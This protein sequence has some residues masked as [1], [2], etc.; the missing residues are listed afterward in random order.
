MTRILIGSAGRRVYLVEW[1]RQA[2]R[3]CEVI[4][5][6][7]ITDHDPMAATTAF[8]DASHVV[9]RYADPDYPR[10]MADLVD[11]I[12]PDLYFSLNDHELFAMAG[13]LADR[14]RRTGCRVLSL[15]VESQ[16]VVTDKY[17]MASALAG[18]GVLT[19][20]TVLA[21]DSEGLRRMA[22]LSRSLIVK[23][24]FGSG[25]VGLHR[26]DAAQADLVVSGLA[27]H[28]SPVA[29]E[30][31]VQPEITGC[32][33]GLDIV[34]GLR[35]GRRPAA[36]L[37]REKVAMRSGEANV[38]TTVDPAPFHALAEALTGL[39]E[40]QGLIDIDV[41]D[42]GG[43]FFVLDINPRFGGGYPFNHQAGADVPAFYVADLHGMAPP[44]GWAEYEIGRTV[45]KYDSLAVL[46]DRG[47][48]SPGARSSYEPQAPN[49]CTAVDQSST[50]GV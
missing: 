31:I 49:P 33:Y 6:V 27:R 18:C 12:A 47:T 19:P 38:A 46:A 23:R 13:P 20:P 45:A 21:G 14:L 16:R 17:A 8:A 44:P 39:L 26:V 24:R 9:P 10:A 43:Q 28:G 1:F 25:S 34:T 7:H 37:A 22:A 32:H 35:G 15:S 42:A 36:V 41:V 30:W 2:L 50:V 11:R 5:E 4:G 3:R 48:S 40:P 29:S